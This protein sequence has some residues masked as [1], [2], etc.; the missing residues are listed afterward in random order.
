MAAQKKIEEMQK[1]IQQLQTQLLGQTPAGVASPVPTGGAA[2][3]PASVPAGNVQDP[4]IA[5]FNLEEAQKILDNP[6]VK[7]VLKLANNK[8]FIPNISAI[9]N[10][11]NLKN[12]FFAQIGLIFFMFLFRMW[13]QGAA[14]SW[15]GRVWVSLY[16]L[17]IFWS[18]SIYFVPAYMLGEPYKKLCL[19]IWTTFT[20]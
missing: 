13:R 1:T 5:G 8:D 3:P 12:L 18:C 16:C 6:F 9:R 19:L 17:V 15:L 7:K 4:A 10:D 11:P 14:Q 20:Q 2:S